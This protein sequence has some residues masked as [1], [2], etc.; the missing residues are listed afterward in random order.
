MNLSLLTKLTGNLYEN[1]GA[2]GLT[3]ISRGFQE[4]TPEYWCVN[5]LL[6]VGLTL[7]GASATIRPTRQSLRAHGKGRGCKNAKNR[8]AK[9]IKEVVITGTVPPSSGARI[10]RLT[11][12]PLMSSCKHFMKFN[13]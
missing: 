10:S 12:G 8:C 7:I 4:Y 9:L 5:R 13:S 11:Q 3:G 2:D 1:L 6:D